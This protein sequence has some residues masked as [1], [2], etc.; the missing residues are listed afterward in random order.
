MPPHNSWNLEHKIH[1]KIMKLYHMLSAIR[2]SITT[3]FHVKWCYFT[4]PNGNAI[5]ALKNKGRFD[6]DLK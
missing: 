6:K 5:L 4:T 2:V 3:Y 1:L